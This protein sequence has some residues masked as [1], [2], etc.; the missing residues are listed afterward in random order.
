MSVVFN[1]MD[2]LIKAKYKLVVNLLRA[3]LCHK[4]VKI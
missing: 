1:S 3:I 2:G 4:N